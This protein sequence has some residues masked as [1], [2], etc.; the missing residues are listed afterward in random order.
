MGKF[1]ALAGAVALGLVLFAVAKW[2]YTKATT[3]TTT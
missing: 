3:K 1:F 2:G